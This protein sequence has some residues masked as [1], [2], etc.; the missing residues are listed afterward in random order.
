MAS[1]YKLF[2]E[3][4]EEATITPAG[5]ALCTKLTYE[6]DLIVDGV[7]LPQLQTLAQFCDDTASGDAAAAAQWLDRVTAMGMPERHTLAAAAGVLGVAP[8]ADVLAAAAARDEGETFT[9]VT[10]DGDAVTVDRCF[11]RMNTTLDNLLSACA[12]AAVPLAMVD[13]P[14]LKTIVTFCAE[15]AAS[16]DAADKWVGQVKGMVN[17]T[18]AAL[19]KA[20]DYLDN[21]VLVDVCARGIA[22]RI[23][24]MTV[25]EIREYTGLRGDEGAQSGD[26]GVDDGD[27]E[28]DSRVE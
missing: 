10:R 8:L 3:E 21:K 22:E 5:F 13:T 9:L 12:K 1:V 17:T 2:T 27:A 25:E 24:G 11:V 6:D 7:A 20:A 15:Y 28:G 18:A 26:E 14:T 23:K 16:R 19:Y 4:Y